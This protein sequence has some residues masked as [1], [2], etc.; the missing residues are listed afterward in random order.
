MAADLASGEW[1]DNAVKNMIGEEWYNRLFGGERGTAGNYAA[2]ATGYTSGASAQQYAAGFSGG[3]GAMAQNAA[4]NEAI[5][6]GIDEDLTKSGETA[7][8]N[9]GTAIVTGLTDT[10]TENAETMGANANTIGQNIDTELAN[11]ITAAEATV[12][13]A[14]SGMMDAVQAELNRGLTIPAPTYAGGTQAASSSAI[15]T[16]S[17]VTVVTQI[18]SQTVARATAGGVSSAQG[19]SYARASTYGR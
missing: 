8:A 17:T 11:G 6:N 18:D 19:T 15:G 13:N 5:M 2:G 9:A 3:Y 10:L 4:I 7:G 14:A 12:V 1:L 16:G